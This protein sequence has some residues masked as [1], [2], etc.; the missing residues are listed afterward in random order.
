MCT[1]H[2]RVWNN[3]HEALKKSSFWGGEINRTRL[4]SAAHTNKRQLLVPAKAESMGLGWTHRGSGVPS[5][6]QRNLGM[7]L[8]YKLQLITDQR[9]WVP[10][11]YNGL[12]DGVPYDQNHLIFLIFLAN[13]VIP[14]LCSLPP[15]WPAVPV[16]LKSWFPGI[17]APN[18]QVLAQEAWHIQLIFLGSLD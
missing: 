17:L 1:M 7:Q 11:G 8:E 2:R 13:L 6:C 18:P 3:A 16:S 12:L 5:C 15:S 4:I 9:G 14:A 10:F